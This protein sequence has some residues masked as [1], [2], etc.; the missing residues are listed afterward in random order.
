MTL[1]WEEDRRTERHHR[2]AE[3][4]K[5]FQLARETAKAMAVSG[6]WWPK[7]MHKE[8]CMQND[9][10]RSTR[11]KTYAKRMGGAVSSVAQWRKL[12]SM[13]Q[14]DI[15][16]LAPFSSRFS[17]SGPLSVSRR[18]TAALCLRKAGDSIR[19]PASTSTVIRYASVTCDRP[20]KALCLEFDLVPSTCWLVPDGIPGRNCGLAATQKE[21]LRATFALCRIIAEICFIRFILNYLL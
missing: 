11:C 13:I 9:A 15:V 20:Q 10:T 14:Q 16:L 3:L 4:R 1:A 19:L 18:E 8:T 2:A 12:S 17:R 21:H 5:R 7:K 6:W